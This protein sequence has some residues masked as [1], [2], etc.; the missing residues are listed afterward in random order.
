MRLLSRLQQVQNRAYDIQST[1]RTIKAVSIKDRLGIKEYYTPSQVEE[2]NNRHLKKMLNI[3]S[4]PERARRR[5][6]RVVSCRKYRSLASKY[7]P[8]QHQPEPPQAKLTKSESQSLLKTPYRAQSSQL[9]NKTQ[10]KLPE[11]STIT[12]ISME[13]SEVDS[14]QKSFDHLMSYRKPTS[15]LK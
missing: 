8:V 3:M 6:Q 5:E 1:N 12:P 4:D 11:I 9:K 7:N 13:P 10:I 14:H 15:L 2:A